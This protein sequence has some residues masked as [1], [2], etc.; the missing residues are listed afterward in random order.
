MIDY[1]DYL[2]AIDEKLSYIIN[3]SYL[4]VVTAG[5]ILTLVLFYKLLKRF[6]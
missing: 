4:M 1:T 6:M 5:V 2:I 3:L